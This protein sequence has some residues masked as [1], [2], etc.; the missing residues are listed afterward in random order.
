MPDADLVETPRVTVRWHHRALGLLAAVLYALSHPFAWPGSVEDVTA[1]LARPAWLLGFVCLVPLLWA[2]RRMP[3]RQ[4]YLFSAWAFVPGVF[5]LLHWLTIAMHV[6][7]GIPKVFSGLLLVLLSIVGWNYMGAAVGVARWLEDRARWP[8][9][10]AVPVCWTGME[11]C[12]A[13]IYFGGFPWGN[14]G[15]TQWNNL[16]VAQLGALGG[17]YLIIVLCGLVNGVLLEV[18]RSFLGERPFPSLPV[19]GAV[20]ALAA[21]YAYG[22]LH[23]SAVDDAQAHAPRVRVGM[24]QGNVEQG[25]KNKT[26]QFREQILAKYEALQRDAVARGAEVVIWPEGALPAHLPRDAD[27][28]R[29]RGLPDLQGAAGIIGT[30]IIWQDPPARTGPECRQPKPPAGCRGTRW[31]HN[32]ALV[33]DPAQGIRGRFDKT[34]LVPFGEYVPWPLG[35]VARAIVPGIAAFVPGQTITPVDVPTREGPRSMGALICYEGIFPQYARRYA[36]RGAQLLVNI[37]NDAWYGI[38]AAAPQHLAFYAMRAAE[39]AR[40][41]ARVANTGITAGIDPVG[42][43]LAPSTLYTDAAVVLDL[44]LMETPTLYQLT[45]DV[46]GWGCAAP[47]LWGLGRG[48]REWYQGVKRRRLEKRAGR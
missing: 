22:A 39:N 13:Y 34:H 43:V 17:V 47:F 25:I 40:A 5:M 10:A 26:M 23:I 3:A 18:L 12:R 36:A 35:L 41:V 28:L 33:V 11:M 32:S 4:A 48:L 19:T 30:D 14:I 37:T 21:S 24:L 1:S 6:F 38:S 7:G 45:G 27:S 15:T 42:R 29:G 2:V 16:Y 31:M 9:W 44:P 8:A 20:L 46:V